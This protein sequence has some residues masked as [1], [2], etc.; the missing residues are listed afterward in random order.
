MFGARQVGWLTHAI[1]LLIVATFL[2]APLLP[3][4]DWTSQGT[5]AGW[6]AG[7]ILLMQTG[8]TMLFG[9]ALKACT[10]ASRQE[11]FTASAT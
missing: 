6:N 2:T 8:C 1:Q 4:A 3:L 9:F 11:I 7:R 5:L 10:T